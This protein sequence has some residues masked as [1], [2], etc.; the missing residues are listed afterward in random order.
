MH[1]LPEKAEKYTYWS[2]WKTH[3]GEGVLWALWTARHVFLLHIS[4]IPGTN[5]MGEV[6][7]YESEFIVVK[8][9][10]LVT[11]VCHVFWVDT[12]K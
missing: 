4:T 12:W 9:I 1:Q 8:E 5:G 11:L 3:M 7:F 2:Q 10:V 6:S